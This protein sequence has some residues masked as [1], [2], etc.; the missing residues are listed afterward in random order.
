MNLLKNLSIAGKTGVAFACAIFA[1]V[2]SACICLASVRA[3]DHKQKEFEASEQTLLLLKDGTSDYLNIIW[4]VLANNLNGKPG[5]KAWI[6]QHR[7]DFATRLAGLRAIDGTAEAIQ[8]A[9][10]CQQEYDRWLNTVV[11][12]LVDMRKKVDAFSVN[13]GDLSA[14][15]EGF[16]SYLGTDRLVAAV[17]KL[18]RYERDR[19]LA[20]GKELV[21][22]LGLFGHA[23]ATQAACFM[24]LA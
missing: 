19:M 4:A 22:R 10:T 8:L 24:R 9:S 23:F 20:S 13:M 3:I 21:Y 7:S 1:F 11:D 6:D 17:D 2:V 18:D 14:L 16:G 12:P 5:H 15:T